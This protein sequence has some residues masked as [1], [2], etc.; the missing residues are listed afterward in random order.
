[1]ARDW[2]EIEGDSK[3]KYGLYLCSREWG[4]LREAVHERA[5]GICERCKKHPIY[6][7]HHLTYIRKYNEE[8]EDLQGLCD[9]CHKY[10]H[11]RGDFDPAAEPEGR[12][13]K[14]PRCSGEEVAIVS[15]DSVVGNLATHINAGNTNLNHVYS[16]EKRW[17]IELTFLCK[18]GHGFCLSFRTGPWWR[19]EQEYGSAPWVHA[20]G[21]ESESPELWGS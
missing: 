13:V 19:V 8:P 21:E 2:K 14:C 20:D 18:C 12:F 7:V 4:A 10:T 1:M 6:A 17:Q 5:S 16:T 9:D 11:K 15:A 3:E